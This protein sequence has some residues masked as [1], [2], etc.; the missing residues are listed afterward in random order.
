MRYRLHR[1]GR[2][3]GNHAH[4]LVHG[5]GL[6]RHLPQHAADGFEQLAGMA[7]G[8]GASAY[9]LHH[10]S[11]RLHRSVR[12]LADRADL[13]RDFL[14]RLAGLVRQLLH[15][16]RHYGEAPAMLAGTGRFNRSV[17]R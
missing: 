11:R 2:L 17:N 5:G 15:F 3:V 6:L 12:I 7:D 9:P 14:R 1:I 10:N 8:F 16:L 13:L 4:R